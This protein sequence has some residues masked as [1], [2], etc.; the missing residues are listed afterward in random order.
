MV[1]NGQLSSWSKRESGVPQGSILGPL[2]FLVHIEDLSEGLKTN[3]RLIADEGSLFYVVNNINLSASNLKGDLSKINVWPNQ[4]KMTFNPNL[5][6]LSQEVI[7]FRKLKTA[8][9]PS[10]NFNNNFVKQVLFQTHV[11]FHL[12]G[13]LDFR[14]HLQNMFKE[15]KKAIS[16]FRKPQNNLHRAPIVATIYNTF[17]WPH[18]DYKDILHGQT[19]NSSFHKKLELIQYNAGLAVTGA[20]RGSCREKFYQELGFELLQQRQWYRKL[21]LF[22]KVI[23]QSPKYL[24]ELTQIATKAYT[25]RYKNSVPTFNVKH[26]YFK[27]YFFPSTTIEGNNVDSNVRNSESLAL[28]KKRMLAFTITFANISLIVDV[29]REE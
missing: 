26:D 20:I 15:V 24:F 18:L 6:K 28:S 9:H 21:C 1:L 19:F 22:F 13:K 12:D 3:A 10:L 23:S 16:L 5:I 29:C 4:W 14:E 27:N 2:L 11:D 25:T 17:I 7:I 8:L